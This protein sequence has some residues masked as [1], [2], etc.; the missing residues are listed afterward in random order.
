MYSSSK[1]SI[2]GK[3]LSSDKPCSDPT[4]TSSC[5]SSQLWSPYLELPLLY[6][7]PTKLPI[8]HS[9]PPLTSLTLAL[10]NSINILIYT[11]KS[12]RAD[13]AMSV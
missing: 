7:H 5:A 1:D 13:F 8:S 10:T 12:V 11:L 9:A 4:T 3:G 6:S 2:L